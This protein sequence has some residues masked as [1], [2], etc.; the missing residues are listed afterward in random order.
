MT[1][2]ILHVIKSSIGG[3]LYSCTHNIVLA[4]TPVATGIAKV[5]PHFVESVIVDS[6]MHYIVFASTPATSGVTI[7]TYFDRNIT[8]CNKCEG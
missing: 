6:R 3:S 7:V 5:M 1:T 2:V 8:S 4:G